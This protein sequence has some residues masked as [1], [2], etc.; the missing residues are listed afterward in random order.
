MSAMTSSDFEE[1]LDKY[2]QAWEC[3]DAE[4]AIRLF[5]DDANYY[6][7]P[8]DNPMIGHEDIRKYWSEGA[9]HSQKDV[10]FSSQVLAVG[11]DFGI[12][13]WQAKFVRVPSGNQVSLDGVLLASFDEQGKCKVF[14]EW[15]HRIEREEDKAM[16]L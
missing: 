16:K 5:T 4:G 12:A 9:G 14:R 7:T 13:R 6:E 1:W 11:E 10:Q 3:G 2:G 15:W 8:F